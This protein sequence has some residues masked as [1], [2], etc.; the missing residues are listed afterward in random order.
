MTRSS[1]LYDQPHSFG[2]ISIALHWTT[3]LAIIALW[4]VGQSIAQQPAELI[5]ARRSL[6]ITLGLLAW[7]PLAGRII[8][9]L[10]IP[11]PHVSGQSRQAHRIARLAHYLILAALTAMIIS[12]PLMAGITWLIPE[13]TGISKLALAIHSNAAIVLATL[14]VLH[15]LGALK[16]LMFHE[17]ETVARIFVPRKD[18]DQGEG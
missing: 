15:I 14:V 16:H 4:F 7:F 5:D 2:W 3:A 10:L 18:D 11:H 1:S 12:G 8:W 17:D 13:Q 9:R 6:H